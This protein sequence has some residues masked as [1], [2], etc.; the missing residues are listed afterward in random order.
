MRAR[1]AF[2]RK[3]APGFGL[4]RHRLPQP[5]D[6]IAGGQRLAGIEPKAAHIGLI[7][8]GEISVRL[9]SQLDANLR[10]KGLRQGINF[11]HR[12]TSFQKAAVL[13]SKRALHRRP[14]LMMIGI[15]GV[16]R[17]VKSLV[18]RHGRLPVPNGAGVIIRIHAHKIAGLAGQRRKGI[19]GLNA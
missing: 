2:L 4:P 3:I 14:F 6:Q 10:L 1:R 11:I 15:F 17:L 8:S 12:E 7:Q 19:A 13:P 18:N 16:N 9:R 5:I